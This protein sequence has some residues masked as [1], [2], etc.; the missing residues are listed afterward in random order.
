M[1]A[2]PLISVI[3]PAYDV[4]ASI[5]A[6]IEG[7]LSQ[8]YKNI[9]LLC[10]DDGS[11][12]DTRSKILAFSDPR[13]V[14]LSKTNGGVSSARNMGLD[15]AKG[16]YISFV[17]PGDSM[18][19]KFLSYLYQLLMATK[20]DLSICS[21]D[22]E[23][24]DGQ[25]LDRGHYYQVVS[26]DT[27]FNRDAALSEIIKPY[28]RFCGHVWDKLFKKSVIGDLRF[29]EDIH[30]CEDT[31]FNVEY[32][33]NCERVALGHEVHYDYVQDSG[34]ATHG[35][36]S[37]KYFTSLLAW[38]RILGLLNNSNDQNQVLMRITNDITNHS[39]LAWRS[40]DRGERRVFKNRFL[41]LM[42]KYHYYNG[43]KPR[44]KRLICKALWMLV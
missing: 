41:S 16:E 2:E 5:E 20:S 40:L 25:I 29:A 21:Y 24:T 36:Y 22:L 30:N 18:D 19:A 15:H 8:T 38:E 4:E 7:M 44:L 11:E 3:V 43:L 1:N 23:T 34:S 26:E 6:T 39:S 33:E 9:E 12:D 32:I 42:G 14:Y 28:G 37:E 27:I 31:L 10:V 17:D 13:V 35:K